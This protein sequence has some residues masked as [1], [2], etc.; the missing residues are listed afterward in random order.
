L[1]NTLINTGGTFDGRVFGGQTIQALGTI[2]GGTVV[3][4]TQ[5][6]AATHCSSPTC[7]YR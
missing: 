2:V 3:G 5:S 7:S 1:G 4:F 6:G